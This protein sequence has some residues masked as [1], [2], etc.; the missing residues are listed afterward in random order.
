MFQQIRASQQQVHAVI[1]SIEIIVVSYVL[2][3]KQLVRLRDV[4]IIT[5]RR[6]SMGLRSSF[7]VMD[8]ALDSPTGYIL[9][10]DLEYP[11]HLRAH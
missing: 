1:R 6:F 7:N 2:Q 4:P 9:K 8:I 3:C 10:V 5:L 11:Q